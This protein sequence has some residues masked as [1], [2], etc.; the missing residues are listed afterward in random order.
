[1]VHFTAVIKL[2]H[3][4]LRQGNAT[5]LMQVIVRPVVYIFSDSN[6]SQQQASIPESLPGDQ[7]ETLP[8][9]RVNAAIKSQR[10]Q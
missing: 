10:N 2:T 9:M 7:R 3:G 8:V 6:T 4:G 5:K 1:M